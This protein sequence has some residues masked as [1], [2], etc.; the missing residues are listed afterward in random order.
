M[1]K[2]LVVDL[3]G[4]EYI[5]SAGLRSVLTP[6]KAAKA[7]G[8]DIRFCAIRPMVKEVFNVSGFSGFLSVFKTLNDALAQMPGQSEQPGRAGEPEGPGQSKQPEEPEQAEQ[9]AQSKQP[10]NPE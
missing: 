10:E 9:A 6:V 8:S 5:S 2:G 1:I 7:A 3:S 4:L